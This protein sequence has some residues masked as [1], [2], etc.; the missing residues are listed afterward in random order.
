MIRKFDFVMPEGK[1]LLANRNA[2]TSN[3]II[4]VKDKPVEEYRS[5]LVIKDADKFSSICISEDDLYT[6][7]KDIDKAILDYNVSLIVSFKEAEGYI[8]Y[9]I[10]F[11]EGVVKATPIQEKA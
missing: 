8:H 11:I 6:K 2:L 9:I 10:E 4:K 5:Y 3:I 1:T 7:Y